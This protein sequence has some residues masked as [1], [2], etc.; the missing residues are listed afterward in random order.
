MP[1]LQPVVITDRQST[2]VSHTFNPEDI[3]GG[4]GSLVESNAEG[5][6]LGDSR[7]TIS[8]KRSGDR[9]KP[10]LRISIPQTRVYTINGLDKFEI[11]RTAYCELKFNF[12]DQ[13]TEEERN[14]MVGMLVSALGTNKTLIHDTIVKLQGVY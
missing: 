12:S 11:A 4:V 3:S 5:V 8:M 14:D 13:S 9:R 7:L 2:P 1:Q 10:E 6:P